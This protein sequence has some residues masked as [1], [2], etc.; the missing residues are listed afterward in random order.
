MEGRLE[1]M[2]ACGADL[3]TGALVQERYVVVAPLAAGGM[4]RLFLAHH[5]DLGVQV[6]L[7]IPDES[8]GSVEARFRSEARMLARLRHSRIV[9]AL[10]FCRLPNGRLCLVM[11]HLVG[12]DL[13]TLLGRGAPLPPRRAVSMLRDIAEA[14]DHVHER[15]V[16]HRDVKP[17][18]V[19][20]TDAGAVLVDFG[21][22]R[23]LDDPE[24]DDRSTIVGTPQY[25]APEQ[26][27]G[28]GSH[29]GAPADRY[30]LAA[31]ALELLSG[32]RPYP[33][34][35]T[36]KLLLTIAESSPRRPTELGI[37]SCALDRVFERALARDPA[38]RFGSCLEMI[39]EIRRAL[40]Q[41]PEVSVPARTGG[42]P[43]T[44]RIR[45]PFPRAA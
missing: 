37:G 14:L 15:G 34:M 44:I 39:D 38:R 35:P 2:D 33:A 16:V 40:R 12:T 18:N 32:H 23:L 31:M 30:A 26:V 11:E 20:A 7:K 17:A 43:P 1:G 42:L 19:V 24:G 27:L 3:T 8:G 6:V 5:L 21:L 45:T 29:V 10:D 22:A 4:A 9:R 36:G 13:A 41:T 28:L 25:M